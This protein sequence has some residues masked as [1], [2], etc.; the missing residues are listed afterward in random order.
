[1]M[2]NGGNFTATKTAAGALVSTSNGSPLVETCSLC[3]GPGAVEDVA[4][5]HNLASFPN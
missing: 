3:H 5:A 1:M 2:Q 4:V